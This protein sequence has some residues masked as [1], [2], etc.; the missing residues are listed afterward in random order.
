MTTATEPRAIA[1]RV[2]VYEDATGFTIQAEMPGVAREHAHVEV[3]DGTLTLRGT[4]NVA[5]GTSTLHVRERSR[6][7]FHRT[8][9]LGKGVDPNNVQARMEDGILTVTLPKSE[10]AQRKSISI[11]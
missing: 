10:K 7:E 5:N 4:Q 2:N 1:P 11:N 3:H 8:F 6:G 9:A